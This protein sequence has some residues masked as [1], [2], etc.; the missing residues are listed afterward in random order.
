M[1]E[2]TLS[3]NSYVWTSA[4]GNE[5]ILIQNPF[6]DV[7]TVIYP[8]G[9]ILPKAVACKLCGK[10]IYSVEARDAKVQ[11]LLIPE[12]FEGHGIQVVMT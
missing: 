1:S 6:L 8:Q 12:H 2:L 9:S 11:W 4:M 3:E 5:P 7:A 10:E